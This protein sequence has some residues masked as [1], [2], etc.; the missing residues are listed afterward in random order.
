MVLA[1]VIISPVLDKFAKGYFK[2]QSRIEK[3]SDLKKVIDD[4][5]II[6]SDDCKFL[7]EFH[8]PYRTADSK[9]EPGGAFYNRFVAYKQ[10]IASPQE[11]QKHKFGEY[12]DLMNAIPAIQQLMGGLGGLRRQ[13]AQQV[14]TDY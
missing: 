10:I 12:G 5:K 4:L 8:P 7:D 6:A 1:V 2:K 13:P 9:I 3:R 11:A 14:G